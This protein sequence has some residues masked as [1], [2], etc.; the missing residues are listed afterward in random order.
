[1]YNLP[2]PWFEPVSS[3]L[4]GGFLIT[5]LSGKSSVFFVQFLKKVIRKHLACF[6]L[7]KEERNIVTF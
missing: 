7:Y 2:E 1:M 4:A 6:K 3:A 5:R